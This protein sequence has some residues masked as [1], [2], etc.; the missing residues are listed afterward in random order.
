M[1]RV[2][3]LEWINFFAQLNSCSP[4]PKSPAGFFDLKA[5]FDCCTTIHGKVDISRMMNFRILESHIIMNVFIAFVKTTRKL[6]IRSSKLNV[7][8][9]T[10][11]Q[12][13]FHIYQNGHIH[14]SNLI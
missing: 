13:R 9:I 10:V 3:N 6:S 14:S 5:V 4:K 2:N 12:Q 7:M 8:A 11:E 1:I